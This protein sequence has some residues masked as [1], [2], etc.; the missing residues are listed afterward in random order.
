[1][2]YIVV[3]HKGTPSVAHATGCAHLHHQANRSQQLVMMITPGT[4]PCRHCLMPNGDERPDVQMT[5]RP[6]PAG[7]YKIVNKVLVPLECPACS[8][9]VT[10]LW[11]TWACVQ[12]PWQGRVNSRTWTRVGG[13]MWTG[14]YRMERLGRKRVMVPVACPK[15]GHH[16]VERERST[17]RTSRLWS[18]MSCSWLGTVHK[19]TWELVKPEPK[20][21]ERP[22]ID[23][24]VVRRQRSAKAEVLG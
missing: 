15:C 17:G 24:V 21:I 19:A 9:E 13:T 2:S 7:R 3:S 14:R 4:L 11:S 6:M 10:R 5:P 8:G 18:C 22:A 20:R 12:C 16:H 23:H 1:M